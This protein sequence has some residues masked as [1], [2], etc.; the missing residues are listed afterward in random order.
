MP[1]S[2]WLTGPAAVLAFGLLTTSASAQTTDLFCQESGMNPNV[3]LYL[4]VDPGASTV[5]AWYTG[6]N[7]N[8]VQPGPATI[9]ADQMIWVMSG[10]SGATSFT[11]D[12]NTGAL[13]GVP[14]NGSQRRFVCSRAS[15]VF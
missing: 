14:P 3:G 15:K 9:S 12:R 10:A 11:L 8:D 2:V 4:S 13:N 5:A 6:F 7:R 1:V